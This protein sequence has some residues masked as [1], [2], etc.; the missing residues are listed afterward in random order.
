MSRLHSSPAP[1]TGTQS[2]ERSFR[3]LKE[4][5]SRHVQGASLPF[6]V[7]ASRLHRTTAHRLLR[8]LVRQGAL[9]HDDASGRFFLG[10]LLAE[11]GTVLKPQPDLKARFGA[12]VARVAAETGDTTFLI[13]RSGND[14]VCLD[15][16]F[17]SYP[18][19]AIVVEIGTRR[20]L[21]I[22][23]GSLAIFSALPDE[24]SAR[25][26]R[27]NARRLADFGRR[28]E[29][30]LRSARAVRRLGYASGPVHG[31]DTAIAVGVPV[32]DPSGA[33]VAGLS[34]AAIASRMSRQ[35]QQ[36]VA[37]RLRGEARR[38]TDLLRESVP[39]DGR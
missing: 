10:P 34:V 17:G 32:L 13:A 22:G 14:A 9:H 39:A 3:L 29:S 11:L 1:R 26:A 6:L 28:P 38:M 19:K 15:R 18:I 24:E 36:A 35:R 16:Q 7:A 2:V 23:A 5:A 27:E 31:V 33:P 25:I 21:G 30:L 37:R 8:C 12:A 20:P 4:V